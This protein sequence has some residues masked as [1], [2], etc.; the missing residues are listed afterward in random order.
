VFQS[1]PETTVRTRNP[2]FASYFKSD[3]QFEAASATTENNLVF[4]LD[5]GTIGAILLAI[6]VAEGN[7][8]TKLLYL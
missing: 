1:G 3:N 5:I 8:W 4:N 6:A 2:H 7:S